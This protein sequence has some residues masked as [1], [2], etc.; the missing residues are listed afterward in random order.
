MKLD[1]GQLSGACNFDVALRILTI[2][3]KPVS[4]EWLATTL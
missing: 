4:K 3:C 2:L 1:L